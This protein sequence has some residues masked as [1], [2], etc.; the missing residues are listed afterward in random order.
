MSREIG[1]W[2][3]KSSAIQPPCSRAEW[4]K[5]PLSVGREWVTGKARMRLT[6]VEIEPQ[7]SPCNDTWAIAQV[8][9][10][11]STNSGARVGYIIVV[12][13]RLA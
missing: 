12:A 8:V 4:R 5:F 11:I 6:V 2:S 13:A 1:I 9:G 7:S 10:T 3:C